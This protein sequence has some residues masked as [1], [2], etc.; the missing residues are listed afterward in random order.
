MFRQK[1]DIKTDRH[2]DGLRERQTD[3]QRERY[4]DRHRERHTSGQREK[5]T[6]GQRGRHTDGQ[7][8]RQMKTEKTSLNQK[9]HTERR[10]TND[11]QKGEQKII[12][13]TFF[14]AQPTSIQRNGIKMISMLMDKNY[15]KERK[16][17]RQ[18]E[19]ERESKSD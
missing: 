5:Y 2:T 4:T 8:K 12:F 16:K 11:K 9:R 17:E 19:Q 1:K 18:K 3:G 13:T 6:D 15:V 7:R 10:D 14:Q